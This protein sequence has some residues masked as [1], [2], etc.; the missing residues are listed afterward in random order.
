M[1]DHDRQS[2][3]V[4]HSTTGEA[5]GTHVP[6]QNGRTVPASP[7]SETRPPVRSGPSGPYG[8]SGATIWQRESDPIEVESPEKSADLQP[9]K[10]EAVAGAPD[11]S[12]RHHEAFQIPSLDGIRG[13]SFLIVFLSHAG[14]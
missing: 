9:P 3:R 12:P 1:T 14:L 5:G 7:P 13:V 10:A 2:P 11:R 8:G 4:G 6:S